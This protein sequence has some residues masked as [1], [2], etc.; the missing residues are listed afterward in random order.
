MMRARIDG[1]TR[2]G[3]EETAAAGILDDIEQKPARARGRTVLIVDLTIDVAL[4]GSRDQ[5]GGLV[6]PVLRPGRDRDARQLALW[7]TRDGSKVGLQKITRVR[8][9][10]VL[11]RY[12]AVERRGEH[13]ELRFDPPHSR[14]TPGCVQHGLEQCVFILR[15]PVIAHHV[16]IADEPLAL[17]THVVRV[18]D[19]ART[20]HQRE[21]VQRLHMDEAAHQVGRRAEVPIELRAPRRGFFVQDRSQMFHRD[22][23]QLDHGVGSR[24]RERGHS[25]ILP[26]AGQGGA[27]QPQA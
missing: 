7:K 4:I 1:E 27:F 12:N 9:K 25:L 11:M 2:S 14:S 3:L 23:A 10:P 13:H 5:A 19:R 20:M 16:Q 26:A 18:S 17:F 15:S 24:V 21:A 22:T 6:L 8:A